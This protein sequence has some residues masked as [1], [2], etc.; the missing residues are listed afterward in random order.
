MAGRILD[1]NHLSGAIV[2]GVCSALWQDK[3]MVLFLTTIHNLRQ[4]VLANRRKPKK[5][6]TN[7]IPA[8]KPLGEYEHR[9]LLP[10]PQMIDNYNQFM[11][12]VHIADQLRSNYPTHQKGWRTWLPLWFWALD[13]TVSKCYVID[14]HLTPNQP[15]KTFRL[16]LARSLIQLGWS[17]EKPTTHTS[18]SA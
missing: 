14:K 7:A 4:L 10:I 15:H 12:G 3:N 2:N 6:S 18:P 9:K 17:I 1:W 5:S 16:L 8:R 13:T 11:G